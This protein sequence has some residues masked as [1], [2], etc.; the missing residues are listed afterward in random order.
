[1]ARTNLKKWLEPILKPR[2]RRN[3]RTGQ[4]E[5]Q[6]RQSCRLLRSYVVYTYYGS[7]NLKGLCGSPSP[8]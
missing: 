8:H 1:M 3:S 2:T 6:P 4:P 5:L 7:I